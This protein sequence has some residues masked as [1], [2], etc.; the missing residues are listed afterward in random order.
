MIKVRN[1]DG[2]FSVGGMRPRFTKRGKTW[3]S[4]GYLKSHLN[5]LNKV[6][7]DRIYSN[8]ELIIIDE[9][10]NYKTTTT[11]FD[12]FLSEYFEG[13]ELTKQKKVL[14]DLQ[15]KKSFLKRKIKELQSEIIA[16]DREIEKLDKI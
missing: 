16:V 11:N 14:S 7:I 13:T 10:D 1:T 4:L 8:C 9:D 2:H 12:D 5:Q 15:Y 3:S 6:E